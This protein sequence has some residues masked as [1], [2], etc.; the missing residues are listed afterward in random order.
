M[1]G[2]SPQCG[3]DDGPFNFAILITHKAVVT[4]THLKQIVQSGTISANVKRLTTSRS[5][6][7]PSTSSS[8]ASTSP[9]SR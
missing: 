8:T 6:R 2:N 9:R 1:I 4:L 3:G 5:P 7:R